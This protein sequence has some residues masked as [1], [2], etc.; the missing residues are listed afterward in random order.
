MAID[1]NIEEEAIKIVKDE[2][3]AWETAEVFVTDKVSFNIRNL[4]KTLRKNYYGI[5]SNKTDPNSKKKKHWVPLSEMVADDYVSSTDTDQKDID[6]E[7]RNPNVVG[8]KYIAK[9]LVHNWLDKHYFGEYLDTSERQLAIDGSHVWKTWE[10]DGDMKRKSVDLLNLYFDMVGHESLQEKHRVTERALMTPDEIKKMDGWINTDDIEGRHGLHP[11]DSNL[12]VVRFGRG[13]IKQVDV[14]ELWGKIPESLITGKKKDKEKEVEGRIIVSGLETNNP[15]VHLIEKNTN[16]DLHGN[17]VRPYEEMHTK[18][19]PNRWLGKGPVESVMMLQSWIN[20]IV[21][22]RMTRA[23]VSQLGLFKIRKGS[24]VTPQS[25]SKLATNG[26]IMVN[27]MDDIEQFVMQEASQASYLDE[28]NA[29]DW[30]KR[31]TKTFETV[32]GEELKNTT[33]TASVIQSRAAQGSF[34]MPRNNIASFIERWLE[35]HAIP[36]LLKN[37]DLEE[38]LRLTGDVRMLDEIDNAISR[39]LLARKLTELKELGATIDPARVELE[40]EKIL[41]RVKSLG[42]SRY[43]KLIEKLDFTQFEINVEV[44]NES[45]DKG[46]IANSLVQALQFVPENR[47]EILAELFDIMG[48]GNL[49]VEKI[50]QVPQV[51][52]IA[53]VQGGQ[54]NIPQTEQEAVTRANVGGASAL[55]PRI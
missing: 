28:S 10:E 20:M 42:K 47:K 44:S 19:V 13:Q 29:I 5:F 9:T 45:Y 24:G 3:E 31:V 38:V 49:A 8:F 36:I 55:A 25:L 46:V 12:S 40:R 21:N 41:Q 48:L 33:A 22:I 2:K 26:G 17:V 16:K 34:K 4:I 23:T 54:V 7:A 14:W 15:R 18:R 51:Q 11:T 1:T 6:L 39:A 27:N 53:G 35:R 50:Q 37:I 43:V 32:T 52:Q 30:A